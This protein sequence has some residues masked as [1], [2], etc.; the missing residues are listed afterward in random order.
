MN[1]WRILITLMLLAMLAGCGN[2]NEPHADDSGH[3]DHAH[4]E[5]GDDHQDHSN[6]EKEDSHDGHASS[7]HREEGQHESGKSGE[8][9]HEPASN[10]EHEDAQSERELALSDEVIREFG[11]E[12]R[13]AG[14]G[15]LAIKREFP[16]EIV[17]DEGLITH[18]TARVSGRAEKLLKQSGEQVRKGDVLAVL[19]SRELARVRSEFLSAKASLEL[20][21]ATF[22]R[23]QKLANDQVAS[24]AEL[25]ESRQ[26]L[27]EA[28]VKVE[29]ARRELRTLGMTPEAIKALDLE[30]EDSLAH[31]ELTAPV[32]G[33]IIERHLTR[34]ER[35]DAD[36]GD[37]PFV[38]ASRDRVW[39]HISVFPQSIDDVR[40]GQS[41]TVRATDSDAS[42]TSPITYVAPL[43]KES[44]RSARARVVLD[45]ASGQWYPGQFITGDVTVDTVDAE[46]VVPQ[47]AVQTMDGGPK[48]FVRTDAGFEARPVE[49]GQKAD[50]K[51]EILQG[52]SKGERYAAVNTFTLKAEFGREKLKHAGHSH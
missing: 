35:V 8:H 19:S 39:G 2:G 12:V 28:R 47:T 41:V 49:L 4:E 17:F 42:A 23:K 36:V 20:A 29:L 3:E 1:R 43:M 31:Y 14:P 11:L 27:S 18:V 22:E 10:G 52:L 7:E 30:S 44:T 48:V 37:S 26:A 9:G 21:R 25:Q 24:E 40:P 32:D 13:E 34:G 45:N 5:K 38:I 33:T 6:H 50:G 51:V 46:V 16:G 15:S